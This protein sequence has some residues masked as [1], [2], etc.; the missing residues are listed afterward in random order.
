MSLAVSVGSLAWCLE[1]GYAEDAESYRADFR[2]INRVLAANGLPPHVEPEVLPDLTD[3]SP[4]SGMPYTWL[5]YLRRA[6]AFARQAPGEFCPVPE[7]EDPWNDPRI[8]RELSVKLNCHLI[9]HS[10]T[11]GFYVPIDFP[12]PLYDDRDDGLVGGILG[13]SPQARREL[14]LTAPLLGIRLMDGKLSDDT[15]RQITD[16]ADGD[17]PYW[18]ER[19]VWLHLFERFRHSIEYGA[20]VMFT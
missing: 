2:E 9:C 12:E 15:A 11:E 14:I 5:H 13:S 20:A 18:V 10:D 7:G 17:H 3:R 1:E 4:L 16:E 6:V 8:D 19:K